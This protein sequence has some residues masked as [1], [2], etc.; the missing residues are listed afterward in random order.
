MTINRIAATLGLAVFVIGVQTP[1]RAEATTYTL[2]L[3]GTQ[4]FSIVGDLSGTV[5]IEF[6]VPGFSFLTGVPQPNPGTCPSNADCVFALQ[7]HVLITNALPAFDLAVN[8]VEFTSNG[9]TCVFPG[10]RN[11]YFPGTFSVDDANRQLT[12][13]TSDLFFINTYPVTIVPPSLIIFDLPDGLAVDFGTPL[14][15]TLP[16]FATGLGALGLLG[17]RRKRHAMSST[18]S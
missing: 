11:L 15:A 7:V 3:L 12:K 2:P 10:C 16:L 6:N 13:T 18:Y 17:W 9:A 4:T 8:G 5:T 14:P 1:M